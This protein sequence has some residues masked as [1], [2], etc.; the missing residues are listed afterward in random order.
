[1]SPLI[2]HVFVISYII[3]HIQCATNLPNFIMMM[4]DDMGWGDVSYNDGPALTP[5]IDELRFSPHT[6]V[7]QRGY[8]Q[9]A[10][11]SP[12]RASVLTGRNGDREC[13]YSANTAGKGHQSA[14]EVSSVLPLPTNTFTI[15]DAVK[16]ADSTYQTAFFGKWHL[17]DFWD[18]KKGNLVSNPGLSGFDYWFAT[19]GNAPTTTPNCGCADFADTEDTCVLGHYLDEDPDAV[20][21]CRAYWYGNASNSNGVMNISYKVDANYNNDTNNER[22]TYFLIT[23][24][25]EWLEYTADLSKPMLVMLW[26]H[27]P[28]A[29]VITTDEFRNGCRNG[30]YC[31]PKINGENYTSIEL[32]YNGC[33]IDIDTQLGRLRQILRDYNIYNNTW[34]WFNS[35]NGPQGGEPGKTNG[36]RG[37]KNDV[38]EGGIRVPTIM[39]WPNIIP[40]DAFVTDYPVVTSDLLPTILDILNVKSDTPDWDIDGVSILDVLKAGGMDNGTRSK[41]IGF[42]YLG[43]GLSLAYMDNE[44]K[45][46]ENSNGCDENSNECEIALYNLDN[47]PYEQN[48]LS[49]IYP[50]RLEKMK[51]DMYKWYKS[52]IKSQIHDTHCIIDRAQPYIKYIIIGIIIVLCC[53]VCCVC[54]AVKLGWIAIGSICWCCF[55]VAEEIDNE[56][57]MNENVENHEKKK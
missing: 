51:D 11:C 20:G 15:A 29:P 49:L 45:V 17:G 34:L 38:W 36:L 47:D 19:E 16:K 2:T 48:D 42:T 44:W 33:I 50:E 32:D 57:E 24:F 28:H 7:F 22:D 43:G 10:L 52:V 25:E 1:M 18:K 35:D 27:A 5:N 14:W 37:R 54:L 23:K 53:C 26:V 6:I 3:T 13:I 30:L 56:I 9:G 40:N 41:P 21:F 46:V 55:K 31:K 4:V 8:S 12:T 39:E